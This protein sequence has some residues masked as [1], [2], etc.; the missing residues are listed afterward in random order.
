MNVVTAK[1]IPVFVGIIA[2]VV[3]VVLA[4]LMYWAGETTATLVMFVSLVADFLLRKFP[5]NK[6]S[7]LLV[8]KKSTVHHFQISI[9]MALVL[10]TWAA[11]IGWSAIFPTLMGV[12]LIYNWLFATE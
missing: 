12:T 3:T 8:T 4:S 9:I 5:N 11:F 1:N 2:S 10:C 6:I 7:H